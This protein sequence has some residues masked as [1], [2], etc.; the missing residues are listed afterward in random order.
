[1]VHSNSCTFNKQLKNDDLLICL[2]NVSAF[3][4]IHLG[5]DQV[6][7]VSATASYRLL[8]KITLEGVIQGEQAKRLKASFSPDVVKLTT[9]NSNLNNSHFIHIN[10][11]VV[12]TC[13]F[14]S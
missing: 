9:E 14:Y 1:M 12:C 6:L 11:C 7:Y 8:P 3:F 13:I 4:L 10:R 2:S 5:A